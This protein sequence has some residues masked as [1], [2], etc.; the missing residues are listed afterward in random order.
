MIETALA[1]GALALQHE[2]VSELESRRTRYRYRR[3]T[4]INTL[5]GNINWM[6]AREALFISEAFGTTSRRSLPIIDP[7]C[8][9]L[10]D[11]RQHTR[12]GSWLAGARCA[13]DDDADPGPVNQ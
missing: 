9:R 4:A 2:H 10:R 3:T 8:F 13:R 11:A 12:V 6:H 1:A 5:R 7:N